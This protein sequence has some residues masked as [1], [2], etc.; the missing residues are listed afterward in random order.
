[1]GVAYLTNQV[2]DIDKKRTEFKRLL[3]TEVKIFNKKRGLLML[4]EDDA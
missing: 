4:K 3:E 2:H 1:M